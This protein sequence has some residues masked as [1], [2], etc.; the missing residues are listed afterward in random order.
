MRSMFARSLC[1][2]ATLGLALP[3]VVRA[4]QT[5]GQ[6]VA[7]PDPANTALARQLLTA[8][9][10]DENL[11]AT[12]EASVSAQRRINAQ[13]PPV[14]YDSLLARMKRSAHEMT[15]SIAPLYA[16]GLS[17]QQLQEMVRFFQS[18]TGQ[19]FAR[20]QLA[21]NPQAAAIGQRWGQRL[22]ADVAKD[23][24]NAGVDLQAH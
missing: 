11:V 13:L 15:D 20:Q 24:V 12:I 10:T 5:A 3:A 6:P 2:A 9:H 14:F 22:G 17:A 7:A 21:V 23:L 4:Q 19:A 1:L 18:P 8:M 16:Q